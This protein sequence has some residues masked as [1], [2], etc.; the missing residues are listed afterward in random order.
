MSGLLQSRWAPGPTDDSEKPTSSSRAP[1]SSS[2]S[3]FSFRSPATTKPQGQNITRNTFTSASTSSSTRIG[4]G[5]GTGTGSGGNGSAPSHANPAQELSRFT[6]LVARLKWKLPFLEEAYQRATQSGMPDTDLDLDPEDINYAATMF[7]ID[8]HEYYALLERAIV[9]LLGVFGV[10]VTSTPSRKWRGNTVGQGV[11]WNTTMPMGPGGARPGV[12][13]SYHANV[14]ETLEDPTCPLHEVLGLG[15][16]REQLRK[17]KEL[18]NRWK[19][20][21]MSEEELEG[22]R[23]RRPMLPLESYDFDHILT[24]IFGGL[25]D[26]YLLAQAHVAAVDGDKANEMEMDGGWDFIVEAMDWEAI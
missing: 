7:K 17:A 25:E 14:L 12:G 4:T 9:H 8:F 15:D 10:Q 11:Q 5:T 18:R 16:V 3:S 26:G 21:D 2:S 6:K 1:K 24:E 22:E 13:H 23:R 19:T 20:A